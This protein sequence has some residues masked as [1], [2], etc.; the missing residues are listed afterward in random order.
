MIAT[1]T[2][3]D[4]HMLLKYRNGIQNKETEMKF[5]VTRENYGTPRISPIFHGE[6]I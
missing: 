5:N 3:Y 4:L 1:V 6:I 2:G